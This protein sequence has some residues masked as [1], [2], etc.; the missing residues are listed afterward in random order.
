MI[1]WT[2]G[3]LQIVELGAFISIFGPKS[4]DPCLP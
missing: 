4:M 2:G 3:Y 1:E